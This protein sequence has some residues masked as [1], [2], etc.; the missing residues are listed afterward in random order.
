MDARLPANS[1]LGFYRKS[2][3]ELKRAL[4]QR[5]PGAAARFAAQHPRFRGQS[6][7][8]VFAA[9][10]SLSDALLV[11]AREQGFASWSEFKKKVEAAAHSP[12]LSPSDRLLIAVR[13]ND[14]PA[15]RELCARHP[16]LAAVPDSKGVLPLVE[17]ADRGLVDTRPVTARRWRGP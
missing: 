10:V 3:K 11:I 12:E 16:G 14:L 6:P 2:A 9:A 15:A 7:A 5:D 4:S 17:A 1:N 8:D 13:A